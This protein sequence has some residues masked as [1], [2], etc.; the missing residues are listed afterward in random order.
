MFTKYF[1]PQEHKST[2]CEHLI[3]NLI[4]YSKQPD[5]ELKSAK[6]DAEMSLKHALVDAENLTRKGLGN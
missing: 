5:D 1:S 3:E 4:V 6:K 2:G